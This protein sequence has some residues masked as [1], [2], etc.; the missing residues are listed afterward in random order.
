MGCL[1]SERKEDRKAEH[2]G[3]LSWFFFSFSLLDFRTGKKGGKLV[4]ARVKEKEEEKLF[5]YC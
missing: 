1:V 5:F 3:K 4:T 2:G